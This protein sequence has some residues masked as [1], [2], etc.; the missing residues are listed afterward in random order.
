MKKWHLLFLTAALTLVLAACGDEGAEDGT[1]EEDGAGSTEEEGSEASNDL[2]EEDLTL[3]YVEWDSEI[4]STHVMQ[5]VLQDEG[6]NVEITPLDN[7][8]MWQSIATDEADAMVS[9]WLPLTHGNLYEEYEDDI[10]D[11]GPNLEGAAIGMVVPEDFPVDSIA[12]LGD[13]ANQTVTAIEPGAGVVQAA[14]RAVDEDYDNL[15]DWEVQTSSSG[16]M[17][18]ELR[19]AVESGEEIVVTG[20]SPHWKF[21]EFDLKYLE[22]PE[23]SFGEAETI[24]TIVREDLEADSP[25]AFTVLDNF[26]WETDHMEEVMLEIEQGA[27]PQEAAESWVEDNA[28][29][30]SEW[31]E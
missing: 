22:D 7:A 18:T 8:V 17:A 3:S 27:S 1:E 21:Q 20:W 26:Y 13:E 16:A 30:V 15:G 23:G 14:E 10:L 25:H 5:K 19:S 6:Y 31:T 9:A 2:G 4:A 12:D 28:D 29:I 11:L 24:N